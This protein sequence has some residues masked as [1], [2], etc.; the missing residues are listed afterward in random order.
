MDNNPFEFKPGPQNQNVSPLQGQGPQI[1]PP[2]VVEKPTSV[3]VF[4]V[5]N[6]VFGGLGIICTPISL[7]GLFI[8]DLL[9]MAQANRMEIAPGYKVFLV[10]SAIAGVCF[11]AWLL[12]LG[13]GLLKMKSW[14]RRGSVIYACIAIVWGIAGIII[15][16]L[17]T[18]LGWMGPAESETP[19]M[20]GGMVGGACGGM[21]GLIY[22]VLLLIFMQSRKVK[23]AF[24]VVGG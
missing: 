3:T 6:C 9:P 20:I 4:G 19:A 12:S 16:V 22:P 24:A 13:I 7:I 8:G 14:A 10:I 2:I 15:T 23:E 21:L 5:L 18:L 11:A 1:L 17:A